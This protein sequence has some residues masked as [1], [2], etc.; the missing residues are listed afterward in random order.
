MY[1]RLCYV[2]ISCLI[3]VQI[4]VS[5]MY[6]F[7]LRHNRFFRLRMKFPIFR[8]KINSFSNSQ[9]RMA[10]RLVAQPLKRVPSVVA[11]RSASTGAVRTEQ[12][13]YADKIG[14]REIVGFGWN[15]LPAY[16]DRPDFPLPAIRWREDTPQI[17]ALR[18][19]EKGDWKKL[20]KNEKKTLYRASFCQTF[21]EFQ[22]PTGEW[23]LCVAGG[24]IA[25][26][27][28]LWIAVW[29]RVFG[30]KSLFINIYDID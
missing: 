27:L 28:A 6:I 17:K 4:D 23:K 14:K 20:T 7:Q 13:I 25:A 11:V 9:T 24:L 8:V 12:D 1:T 26:T 29:M 16:A 3:F 18:E 19:K 5:R 30:R 15:G 21:A 2:M 10:F 22:A